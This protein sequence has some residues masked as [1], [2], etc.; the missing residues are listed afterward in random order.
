MAAL[1]DEYLI[2]ER[3]VDYSLEE[4][5]R[6]AGDGDLTVLRKH[7]A[8]GVTNVDGTGWN[9]YTALILAAD[10][11]NPEVVKELLNAGASL[12]ITWVRTARYL[13]DALH[14]SCASGRP[15]YH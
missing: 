13:I 3:E 9:G 7:L 15:E 2:K 14:D 4:F 12:H 10:C 6:A 5:L 8:N 11:G 1:K